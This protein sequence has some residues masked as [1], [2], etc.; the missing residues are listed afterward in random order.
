[1]GEYIKILVDFMKIPFTLF[2]FRLSFWSIF[3]CVILIGFLVK[4]IRGI[5]E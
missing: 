5:F 3:L 2:G 1:M 4:L